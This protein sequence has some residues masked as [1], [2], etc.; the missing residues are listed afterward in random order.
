MVDGFTDSMDM[1]LCKLWGTVKDRE[2]WRA[3][4]HVVAKSQ[5][6]NLV[7]TTATMK[8]DISKSKCLHQR[9]LMCRISPNTLFISSMPD[10]KHLPN[11]FVQT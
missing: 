11:V 4:V 10:L 5:S 2:A 8:R 6:H 9:L 7:T 3:A 1:S